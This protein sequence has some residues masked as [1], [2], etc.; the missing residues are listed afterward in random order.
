M[1]S[2][3]GR[4]QV[5]PVV[6]ISKEAICTRNFIYFEETRKEAANYVRFGVRLVPITIS[7]AE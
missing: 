5:Q 4:V 7:F 3:R 1:R 2:S 6:E